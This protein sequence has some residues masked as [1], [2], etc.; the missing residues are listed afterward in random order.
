M[1]LLRVQRNLH[2]D[3]RH[4]WSQLF[5][6]GPFGAKIAVHDQTQELEFQESSPLP[7]IGQNYLDMP[8]VGAKIAPQDRKQDLEFGP[9]ETTSILKPSPGTGAGK[10]GGWDRKP[11]LL[12]NPPAQKIHSNT[13][14][15]I[16]RGHG[17]HLS[18]VGTKIAVIAR[19]SPRAKT[20]VE[21][22]HNLGNK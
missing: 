20:G 11:L 18:S 2:R 22:R 5:R 1:E 21:V 4:Y 3:N 14:R 15:A 16:A 9:V 6:Q 19:L 17:K 7:L 8:S 13:V 12:V 10:L